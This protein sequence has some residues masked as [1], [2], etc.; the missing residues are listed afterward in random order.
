MSDPVKI[1]II[2]SISS[3]AVSVLTMIAT[4]ITA[5]ISRKTHKMVNSRWDQFVVMAETKFRAEGALQE[6][7]DERDRQDKGNPPL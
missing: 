3:V 2:A 4:V 5:M 7:N 1:A 6:K